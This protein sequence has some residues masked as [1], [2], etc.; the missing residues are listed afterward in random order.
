MSLLRVQITQLR[1]HGVAMADSFEVRL[2]SFDIR[3]LSVRY[4]TKKWNRSLRTSR[5][6]RGWSRVAPYST[7]RTAALSQR[8]VGDWKHGPWNCTCG[9]SLRHIA[10]SECQPSHHHDARYGYPSSFTGGKWDVVVR[11]PLCPPPRPAW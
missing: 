9:N 6:L 8:R 10:H 5:S 7:G 2:N 1:L 11:F 3:R 4:A